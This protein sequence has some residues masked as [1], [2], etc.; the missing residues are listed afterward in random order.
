MI[1]WPD[2]GKH[3][4]ALE[5]GSE[6]GSSSILCPLSLS[7][8]FLRLRPPSFWYTSRT[9][10]GRKSLIDAR[11][12]IYSLFS[13]SEQ[14]EVLDFCYI[15]RRLGGS[16]S[17]KARLGR[18]LI[19][20]HQHGSIDWTGQVSLQS[21]IFSCDDDGIVYIESI[22]QYCFFAVRMKSSTCVDDFFQTE[23]QSKGTM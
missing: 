5:A 15:L 1:I 17:L 9:I 21:N 6:W 11:R 18:S 8:S 4:Q 23:E 7:L 14:S 3:P 19:R 12:W 10:L 22:T 20:W 16:S 2:A 13:L